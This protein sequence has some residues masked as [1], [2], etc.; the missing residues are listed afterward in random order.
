M[1]SMKLVTN[2]KI[3]VLMGGLS[4]EREVS[5]ASGRAI[6]GALKAKGY[7]TVAVDVGRDAAEQI[8]RAGVEVAFIALHGTF[9]EDG[10]IQ[11]L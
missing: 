2:K 5:L 1:S 11:G 6:L 9:G 7:N 4:S 10:A 8:A 3:G